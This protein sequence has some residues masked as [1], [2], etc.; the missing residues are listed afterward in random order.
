MD[1]SELQQAHACLPTSPAC[2]FVPYRWC[3]SNNLRCSCSLPP[4][5]CLLCRLVAASVVAFRYFLQHQ[6]WG[7]HSREAA[8]PFA[9]LFHCM[10]PLSLACLTLVVCLRAG[11][12]LRY[13]YSDVDVVHRV[14][15]SACYITDSF[16]RFARCWAWPCK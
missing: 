13:G 11:S 5:A 1:L 7:L 12:V 9:L 6:Q 4:L 2:W 14:Y 3:L 8:G 16:P 15:G 10:L